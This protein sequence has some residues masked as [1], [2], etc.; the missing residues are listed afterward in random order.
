MST[1]FTIPWES[2]IAGKVN[3]A[4]VRTALGIVLLIVSASK[5]LVHEMAH[6]GDLPRSEAL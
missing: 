4:G 3:P 5:L 2:I 1:L 6:L